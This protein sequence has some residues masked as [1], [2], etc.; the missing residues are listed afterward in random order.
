[1][2]V[3][4]EHLQGAYRCQALLGLVALCALTAPSVWAQ[5]RPDA[6]QILQETRPVPVPVSPTQPS[7]EVPKGP[8]K[9]DTSGSDNDARVNVTQ[10]DFVGNT[11][12]SNRTLREALAKWSGRPLNFGE[13]IEAVEAVEATYK[14]AGFFLAQASLPPQKIKDGA[15]EITV[16][17][18]ILNE[19]RLEGE[20]HI[21]ADTL[22]AYTDRIGKGEPLML[23][24]VERQ[25]LL[26]NELAGGRANLDLQAGEAEGSS[27]VVL[28]MTPDEF[29]TGRL[30]TNNHG[31]P[32]TG[33]FRTGITLN[34]KSLFNR[35]ERITFNALT[36][37]TNGLLAYTLRG[38]APIGGDGWRAIATA[39]RAAYTLGGTFA[40]LRASG[41]A[42]S[43]RVGLSYPLIRSRAKNLRFQLEGDQSALN[44]NFLAT[45]K[46]LAKNSSGQT[47]TT[48]ADWNDQLGGGG[49]NRFDLLVRTGQLTMNAAS[50][51]EDT[52]NTRGSFS[53]LALNASRQQVLGKDTSLQLALNWQEAGKNLD[54][55]EKLSMG[56]PQTLPGYGS[57][58]ALGDSGHLLKL[59]SRWQTSP[60]LALS[61][62]TNY[63]SLK[64]IQT[65]LPTSTAN[66]ERVLADAGV[67]ADWQFLKNFSASAL[68]A[69][70][71]RPANV[72][73]DSNKTRLWFT[74][75]Y[76]F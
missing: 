58:E 31:A 24:K 44:D 18:G 72:A 56:G 40:N 53:K 47:L 67:G 7:I 2:A 25:I 63:A 57:G 34:G 68:V 74:V 37:D 14:A 46:F 43:L 39:S 10:F 26:I 27:D 1:M 38:D 12:L 13:L 32:S 36:S 51:A 65:P 42:E 59:S 9:P 6:G 64:L 15:I 4:L 52:N 49:A 45:P 8:E 33:E 66:N 48:S 35:G 22:Y 5:V 70:P 17:E 16:S 69:W 30:E 21:G 23:L 20:S 28:N 61:A 62:F 29:V 11:A 19:I 41:T 76:A 50:A 71:L 60:V 73:A 55:S 54:S 3:K 75:A